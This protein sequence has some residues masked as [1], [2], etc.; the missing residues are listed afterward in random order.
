MEHYIVFVFVVF[1][2]LFNRYCNSLF[3]KGSR[4]VPIDRP[5]IIINNDFVICVQVV[6]SE[7]RPVIMSNHTNHTVVFNTAG[8]I[9]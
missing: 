8:P 6:V 3:A 7:K 5:L 9:V 4:D 2:Q 1:A